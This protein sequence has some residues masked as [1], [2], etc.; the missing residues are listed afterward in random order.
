[1]PSAREV[2]VVSPSESLTSDRG[3]NREEPSLSF[4]S[5]THEITRQ[6][7]ILPPVAAM[8]DRHVAKHLG[9]G[10]PPSPIPRIGSK[11]GIRD[12]PFERKLALPN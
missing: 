8:H 7:T 11:L 1:M 5:M 10:P 2:G 3:P 9:A 12:K 4:D 6:D